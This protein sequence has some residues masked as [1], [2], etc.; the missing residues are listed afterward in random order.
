MNIATAAILD[1]DAGERLKRRITD[2]LVTTVEA[3]APDSDEW[4]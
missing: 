4:N 2:L 1:K 3:V